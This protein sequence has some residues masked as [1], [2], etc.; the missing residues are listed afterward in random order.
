MCVGVGVGVWV[1]VLCVCLNSLHICV[2]SQYGGSTCTTTAYLFLF[3]ALFLK[4]YKPAKSI[5]ALLD[6]AKS[7]TGD[8]QQQL[9]AVKSA[10]KI[11]LSVFGSVNST[12]ADVLSSAVE[13]LAYY[14][15]S[16]PD[17]QA[18]YSRRLHELNAILRGR[19]DT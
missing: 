11:C 13:I 4:L 10:E 3:A 12:M 16:G 14:P 7:N 18:E 5:E 1:G 9:K 19:E 15:E 6:L 2:T 8:P 17:L